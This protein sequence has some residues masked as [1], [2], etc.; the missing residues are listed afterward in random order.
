MGG[1]ACL[2]DD[3]ERLTALVPLDELVT[4]ACNDAGWRWPHRLD[5]WVTLH[6][7]RFPGWEKKRRQRGHPDGYTRWTAKGFE[8]RGEVDRVIGD[9]MRDGLSGGSSGL[10]A[11]QVAVLPEVAGHAVGCGIPISRMRHFEGAT[12]ES[13]FLTPNERR[14]ER[15]V[16]MYQ[17]VWEAEADALRD[18]VRSMSGF[19]RE[20]FGEPGRAW[21]ERAVSS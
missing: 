18:R 9:E 19:T 12:S 10:T 5:H 16:R 15:K 1:A 7:E 11:T 13:P 6:A 4:V 3:V 14:D 17:E 8:C 2:D 21:L 20:L